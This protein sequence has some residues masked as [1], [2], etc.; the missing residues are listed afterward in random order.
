MV[1]KQ[2]CFELT[3]Q[4]QTRGREP[5]RLWLLVG[6]FGPVG[7]FQLFSSGYEYEYVVL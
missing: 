5:C 2:A 4:A 3:Y 6:T 7:S 1:I